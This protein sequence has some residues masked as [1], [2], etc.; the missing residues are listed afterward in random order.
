MPADRSLL[1]AASV[2]GKT[3]GSRPSR[4]SADLRPDEI[5]T[6]PGARPSRDAHP[7]RDPR[8]PERGQ[9]GFVQGLVREVAYGTLAKRDRRRMHLAAARFFETLDDEGIAGALAEH[10]LAAYHA[11]PDGPEGEAVAAQAR[12]ALRGAAER[13]R[14]L[15]SFLQASRF[16][17]QALEV[18]TD[19]REEAHSR[20]PPARRA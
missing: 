6:A 4:R 5:S 19:S 9:Y 13:A 7:G 17:E 12:V 2:I 20:L 3:F 10:Y 14:S 15:G 1:Q 8:S 18:T 16:L 11:Q